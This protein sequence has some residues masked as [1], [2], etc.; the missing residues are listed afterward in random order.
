LFFFL[1]PFILYRYFC[2]FNRFG[3]FFGFSACAPPPIVRVPHSPGVRDGRAEVVPVRKRADRPER[4]TPNDGTVIAGSLDFSLISLNVRKRSLLLY[5]SVTIE[6]E[7]FR[8]REHNRIHTRARATVTYGLIINKIDKYTSSPF[9]KYF[10][11]FISRLRWT[12]RKKLYIYTYRYGRTE[13]Y[14]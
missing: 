13:I 4:H 14:I 8:G 11:P 3:G 5:R 2:S 9:W 12:T 7:P 10:S 1:S 6:N